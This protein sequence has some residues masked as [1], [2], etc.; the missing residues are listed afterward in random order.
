MAAL[1]T[2]A[3]PLELLAELPKIG[4]PL[5][6]EYGPSSEALA[7]AQ[8][9]LAVEERRR[10]VILE[11]WDTERKFLQSLTLV[12]TLY[13]A[14]LLAGQPPIIPPETVAIIMSNIDEIASLAREVRPR[15]P[16]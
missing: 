2:P 12:Q 15:C 6:R 3:V 9:E 13:Q 7:A 8:R 11:I 10:P 4:P 5:A 14:P 1:D 16:V